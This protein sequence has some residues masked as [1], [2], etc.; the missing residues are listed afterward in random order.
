MTCKDTIPNC[1]RYSTFECNNLF[2]N[3]QQ[4]KTLCQRSCATCDGNKKINIIKL[5]E[6]DLRFI[7]W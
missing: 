7:I 3:G 1:P 2:I 6:I 4:A 5:K